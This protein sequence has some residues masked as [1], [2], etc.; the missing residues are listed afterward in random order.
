M[1][2]GGKYCGNYSLVKNGKYMSRIMHNKKSYAKTFKTCKEAKKWLYDLSEQ[3]GVTKNKYRVIQKDD[4]S[5]LE[6]QLVGN[7]TFICDLIDL[8]YVEQYIWHAKKN[9]YTYYVYGTV[10][11]DEKVI[12]HRFIKPW[13]DEK[14]WEQVD[15]IN[16]NGWDNRRCN[17]RDGSGN[18]NN[19]NQ[20]LRKDNTSGKTGIH[21]SNYMNAWVVQWQED[22][23][24]KKK[25]YSVCDNSGPKKKNNRHTLTRTYSQAKKCAEDFR[26]EKDIQ[27]QYTNGLPVNN[28]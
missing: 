24:R 13:G 18:I 1:W 16:R 15:H 10:K 17:L 19:L 12:F 8:P 11:G 3:F 5:C 6:V 4:V 23:K 9:E 7:K 20:R 2:Q 27:L 25:S 22:G 14:E 21:F 28:K 26:K